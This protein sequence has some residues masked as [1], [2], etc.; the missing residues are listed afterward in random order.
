MTRWR[1][2]VTLA[3]ALTFATGCTV[4]GGKGT[5]QTDRLY[6][7]GCWDGGFDLQPDFFAANPYRTESMQIR[8]QRGDNNEE[9]SDGLTVLVNDLKT[10]RSAMLGKPIPVGLPTGVAPPGQP[11]TGRPNPL[12]S[13][14]LYLHQTCHEQNSATYSVEG[15]ITFNSLF[16]GDPNE[17]DPSNRLT[18]AVF[19]VHFA[20]P[21][22][23]LDAPDP[24]K[25]TSEKVHGEFR[26]YFQRGQPAQPFQ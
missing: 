24:A 10:V 6:L 13:L 12:V 1:S 19:D 5:V 25:V 11:L 18:D 17:E 21:R 20:D 8:V 26:F 22:D 3:C 15:E 7:K 9:A 4:G 16:N 14:S 23:L 2:C